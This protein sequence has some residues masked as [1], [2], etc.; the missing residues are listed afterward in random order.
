MSNDLLYLEQLCSQFRL[1]VLRAIHDNKSGHSGG[2]LSAC[3]ILTAIYF[4][5]AEVKPEDPKDRNQDRI[6]LSKGHAAPMLYRILAEKGYLSME[7]F[8]TFRRIDSR[9]QG[10][11]CMKTPGVDMPSGPLGIGLGAAVGIALGMKKT[12]I[13]RHVYAVMGDGELNEGAVWEAAMAAAKFK[14]NNLIIT[15]DRNRYQ[16]DG[17]GSDIMPMEP[18]D[19]KWRAFGMK[20]LYCDGHDL[21]ALSESF[22]SAKK[23]KERPTV[24]L[25]ETVKGK[26][27]S[28]MENTS[29][30]H[31]KQ[32]ED[33]D[34][35]AAEAE[36]REEMKRFGKIN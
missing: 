12:G 5:S 28:F 35:E 29:L 30:W 27:V 24:I 4:L 36:I 10:H 7:E 20:V 19:E 1:D 23:E 17:A 13:S 9:L 11:P 31:G 25:A 3:E 18:L 15:V 6:V 2:S 22:A 26:G 14:L 21:K 32:V 16:L 33:S 34:L 8:K